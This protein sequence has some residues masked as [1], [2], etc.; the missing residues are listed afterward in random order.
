M[1]SED[2]RQGVVY[3]IK[4][5][6]N[7]KVY[8]GSTLNYETR[9][10][11]HL[12]NVKHGVDRCF[13]SDFRE[14]PYVWTIEILE[15]NVDEECL[16]FLEEFYIK[17]FDAVYNGYNS[18]LNCSRRLGEKHYSE[19]RNRKISE[20]LK[21]EKNPNYGKHRKYIDPNDKSKGWVMV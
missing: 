2:N 7:N 14:N 4:N 11:H 1:K 9:I 20:S 17:K 15:N 10:K 13:Y 6:E 3:C 5:I 19:E 12:L 16:Q 18:T 21:G 8:I